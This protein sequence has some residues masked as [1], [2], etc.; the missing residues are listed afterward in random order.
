MGSAHRHGGYF[1]SEPPLS[2]RCCQWQIVSD[3]HIDTIQ[4]LEQS[5]E[6]LPQEYMRCLLCRPSV[7]GAIHYRD[8]E[9]H[10]IGR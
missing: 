4:A 10:F 3:E 8:F 7:G 1:E 9:D 5:V 6:K 2:M